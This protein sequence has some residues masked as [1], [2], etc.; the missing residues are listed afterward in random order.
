MDCSVPPFP[1]GWARLFAVPPTSRKAA[2]RRRLALGVRIRDV[3][4]QA[5]RTQ[6]DIADAAGLD[7]TTYGRIEAGR[8]SA[9]VDAVF[10]IAD[11]LGVDV[12]TLF[13]DL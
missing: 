9:S 8:N 7:R 4:E 3:R 13:T 10:Q 11:A 1:L 12:A 2:P 5:N 6:Q